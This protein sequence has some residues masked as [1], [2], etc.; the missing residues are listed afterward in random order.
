MK[1]SFLNL[2]G[3]LLLAVALCT[4]AKADPITGSI[5][6]AGSFTTNNNSDFTLATGITFGPAI[7]IGATSGDY[8][9]VPNIILV[10]FNDFTF[11]SLPTPDL[12]D[13]SFWGKSY[14]F[15]ATSLNVTA[16]TNTITL[17]GGGMAHITGRDDTYGDWV[18]TAN[19]LGS[20]FTFSAS[21]AAPDGGTTALLVGLGL[22]SMGFVARRRR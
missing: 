21:T 13:F 9:Y 11:D 16:T 8:V 12:W 15:K 22:A 6:F 20:N 7:T 18:I 17:S 4:S 10:N 19:N 1:K 14:S 3:A 2:A 5:G